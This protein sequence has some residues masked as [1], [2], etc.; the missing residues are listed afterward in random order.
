MN[1][2]FVSILKL[3]ICIIFCFAII[4]V[5]GYCEMYRT[6]TDRGELHI[7]SDY[8]DA[9]PFKTLSLLKFPN[10][11]TEI[12]VTGFLFAPYS[13]AYLK[14]NG[15][16]YSVSPIVETETLSGLYKINEMDGQDGINLNDE[17]LSANS[18]S[19]QFQVKLGSEMVFKEIVLPYKVV[20]EWH[21]LIQTDVYADCIDGSDLTAISSTY[22]LI[23][24]GCRGND[25][26]YSFDILNADG[27]QM[28]YSEARSG[29]ELHKFYPSVEAAALELVP[30]QIYTW[31]VW[32]APSGIYA[33]KGYEGK[34]YVPLPE[35][36]NILPYLSTHGQIQWPSRDNDDYFYCI[37]LFDSKGEML[38][39]AVQ[40][41]EAL[42]SFSP[43]QSL[44]LPEGQYAWKVWSW[45]SNSYG[46]TNFEGTFSVISYL[47]TYEL[48]Q[49]PE[50]VN[51]DTYY[52][53]D[54]LDDGGEM[55]FRAAACGE[56]LY[57][58]KPE[59]ELKLPV[60]QYHW[61]IWSWPSYSYGGENFEG[62]FSVYK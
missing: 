2:R 35:D 62:S 25:F 48:I 19:I 9:A 7:R 3:C 34:F 50:R 20:D 59:K 6:L 31:K 17:I 52:C 1:K 43:E 61:I 8:S 4:P 55:L 44:D 27:T 13:D 21:K 23:Q 32:S 22:D 41:G 29:I 51:G 54:I 11:F 18:I 16:I 42:H 26:Y 45:P 24:W 15:K 56:D 49:W 33:G 30:G 37:D 46:G 10:N 40:C 53:I 57:S 38:Y 36:M 39:Q 47:S 60:G 58:F 5:H 12:K 14:L 28:L